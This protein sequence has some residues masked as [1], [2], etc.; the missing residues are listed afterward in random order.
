MPTA[1]DMF[2][3]TPSILFCKGNYLWN[4][5]MISDFTL[6]ERSLKEM[7][8]QFIYPFMATT[9]QLQGSNKMW[10]NYSSKLKMQVL[11]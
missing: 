5:F 3:S 2:P 9:T 10:G 8:E 7:F 6:K 1:F 4:P 11:E